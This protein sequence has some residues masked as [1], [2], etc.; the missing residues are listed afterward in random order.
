LTTQQL[1]GVIQLL[2]MLSASE[3]NTE[4]NLENVI[5]EQPVDLELL[6]SLSRRKGGFLTNKL[7]TRIWPKLLGINR[8]KIDDY[9]QYIDPHR[10]NSQVKCDVERSLWNI[11]IVKT[12]NE[13]YRERRRKALLEIIMAILCRNQGMYYYQVSGIILPIIVIYMSEFRDFMIL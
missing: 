1:T 6:R 3:I 13:S 9:L 8:Y 2:K 10:D 12:W 4:T 5:L 7:R 11:E